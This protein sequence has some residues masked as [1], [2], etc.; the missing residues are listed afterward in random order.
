MNGKLLPE[1]WFGYVS[2][3]GFTYPAALLLVVLTSITLMGVQKYWSTTM[4]REREKTLLF[5]GLQIQKAIA[6]YYRHTPGEKKSFPRSLNVLMNDTRSG[7]IRRHL[8]RLYV[9]PMTQDGQ[10][11]QVLDGKGGIK[12]V[13]SKSNGKPLK[14]DLFPAVFSHF[15]DQ[16]KYSAWKFVFEPKKGE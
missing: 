12:G 8:R 10:W 7:E 6:S 13:F 16:K 5:N 4:Q 3:R 14:Q 9:D 15:R 1:K 2:H 11:G